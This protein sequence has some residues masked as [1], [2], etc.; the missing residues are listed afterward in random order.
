V[1]PDSAGIATRE[2]QVI[3]ISQG[4]QRPPQH[5][6][7]EDAPK[8]PR[9]PK[10][11]VFQNKYEHGGRWASSPALRHD[12]QAACQ[13]LQ[14]IQAES[15]QI[16]GVLMERVA[17]WHYDVRESARSQYPL[18]FPHDLVW[19][20]YVFKNCVTLNPLEQATAKRKVVGVSDHIHA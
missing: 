18:N 6:V 15:V 1:I 19:M 7:C 16:D 12:L 14:P 10:L 11:N 13:F 8:T 17:E 5:P 3:Q 4:K 9:K 2:K 20:S